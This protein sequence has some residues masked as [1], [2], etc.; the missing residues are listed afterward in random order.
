MSWLTGRPDREALVRWLAARNDSGRG[1]AFASSMLEHLIRAGSLTAAQ[2][3]AVLRAMARVER[4][5][6]LRDPSGGGR[7]D[8]KRSGNAEYRA[9]ATP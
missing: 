3:A 2:E 7:L 8:G 4:E 6:A 1:G 9:G 5:M